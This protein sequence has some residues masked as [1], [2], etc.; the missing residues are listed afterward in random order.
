MARGG[1]DAKRTEAARGRFP[2]CRRRSTADT[3][4]FSRGGRLFSP[5]TTR[6][7]QT[8]SVGIIAFLIIAATASCPRNPDSSPRSGGQRGDSAA[9]TIAQLWLNRRR[10]TGLAFAQVVQGTSVPVLK[11]LVQQRCDAWL[12]DWMSGLLIADVRLPDRIPHTLGGLGCADDRALESG[13]DS[14]VL[15]FHADRPVLTAHREDVVRAVDPRANDLSNGIRV[16]PDGRVHAAAVSTD[17][18]ELG[19]EGDSGEHGR[20]EDADWFKPFERV[21]V[22]HSQECGG[23]RFDPPDRGIAALFALD[24]LGARGPKRT[25]TGISDSAVS[26]DLS[27]CGPSWVPVPRPSPD[28]LSAV[29]PPPNQV[30]T[31][32]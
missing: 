16:D 29:L 22:V 8:L 14:L 1:I 4:I 23:S 11:A 13:L 18:E 27:S 5:S 12:G 9:S 10:Q 15:S 3:R 25:A 28:L 19:D 26:R 30:P 7:H 21:V 32:A 20:A 17:G 24:T 31:D 2:L 6:H